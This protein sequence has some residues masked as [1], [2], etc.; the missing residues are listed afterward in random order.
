MIILQGYVRDGY[1]VYPLNASFAS[2]GKA[3]KVTSQLHQMKLNVLKC[4]Q[5]PINF[6]RTQSPFT[7]SKSTME[8]LL[9]MC[10]CVKSAQN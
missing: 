10:E 1:N 5:V 8:T 9:E 6:S 7:S 4:C 2:G 3:E